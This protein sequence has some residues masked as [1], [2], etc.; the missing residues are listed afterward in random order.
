MLVT[1]P[2]H[3][4]SDFTKQGSYLR[5]KPI[6]GLQDVIT[7]LNQFSIVK[8]QGYSGIKAG[9]I[10]AC[11]PTIGC[12]TRVEF[13]SS[14]QTSRTNAGFLSVGNTNQGCGKPTIPGRSNYSK[15]KPEISAFGPKHAEYAR[16]IY[17]SKGAIPRS[18]QV[19]VPSLRS[20]YGPMQAY[21]ER[22]Q[23]RGCFAGERVSN[24]KNHLIYPETMNGAVSVC[25]A[26]QPHE[27]VLRVANISPQRNKEFHKTEQPSLSKSR[28]FY[29]SMDDNYLS[30][31]PLFQILC[32]LSKMQ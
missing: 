24:T 14:E 22:L 21:C 20:N 27:T 7:K 18:A 5:N 11:Q 29:E 23:V 6:C 10:R 4:K 15:N 2:F 25:V 26:S 17:Q 19:L 3:R 1:R 8:A 13:V 9:Q 32:E 16:R 31:G 12:N 28:D 30:N